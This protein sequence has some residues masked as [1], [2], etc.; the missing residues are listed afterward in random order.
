MEATPEVI[1]EQ[2]KDVSAGQ[3]ELKSET[4][5]TAAELKS[6]IYA[7]VKSDIHKIRTDLITQVHAMENKMGNCM[8]V[9]RE[10]LE[11]HK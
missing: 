2:L 5:S 7:K 10:D 3:G 11:T 9:I 1:M 6:E 8:S 4:S